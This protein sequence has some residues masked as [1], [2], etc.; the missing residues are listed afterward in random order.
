MPEKPKQDMSA[1]ELILKDLEKQ[2]KALPE[3][4]Q[5]AVC[6][7][8]N[9]IEIAEQL[10]G[11]GKIAE[12]EIKGLIQTAVEREDYVMLALVLY[13]KNKDRFETD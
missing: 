4:G 1:K 11:G 5:K 10:A 8:I 3:T 9:N 6:W 12:G 13:K 7:F 2:I